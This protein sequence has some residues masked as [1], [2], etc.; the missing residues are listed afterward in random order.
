M[1]QHIN[2]VFESE[3]NYRYVI[4]HI[5]LEA[6]RPSYDRNE[7]EKLIYEKLTFVIFL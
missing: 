4:N 7:L 1:C 3:T 6:T 5:D 2:F